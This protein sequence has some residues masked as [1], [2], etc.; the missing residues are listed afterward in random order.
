M[1]VD[2]ILRIAGVGLLVA[3]AAQILSKNGRDEQASFVTVAGMIVVFF[4][5]IR[6]IGS[7]FDTVRSTFGF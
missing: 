7:L 4:I 1:D 3:I 2:L 6:E 5:L